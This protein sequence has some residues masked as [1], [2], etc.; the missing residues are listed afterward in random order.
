[1]LNCF[2]KNAKSKTNKNI[3]LTIF[4]KKIKETNNFFKINVVIERDKYVQKVKKELY[5]ELYYKKLDVDPTSS[6]R[7]KKSK[8]I[9]SWNSRGVFDQLN[10]PIS[11]ETNLDHNVISRAYGLINVHSLHIDSVTTSCF[12]ELSR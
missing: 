1:M 11:I 5:N 12:L 6:L 10:F 8:L 7:T 2:N 9:K 4:E 3:G